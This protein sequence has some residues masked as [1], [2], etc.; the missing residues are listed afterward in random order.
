MRHPGAGPAE[1]WPVP[2]GN[3]EQ[4]EL[5]LLGGFG[6]RHGESRLVLPMTAQR[7]LAFLALHERTARAL[8]TGTLW[9]EASEPRAQGNLRTAIWRTQRSAPLMIDA[10]GDTLR[11]R[12]EVSVD[13]HMFTDAA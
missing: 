7:L 5:R 1:S 10:E 13:F 8:I 12:P 4:A 6:L 3:V 9:P 11:L 2:P